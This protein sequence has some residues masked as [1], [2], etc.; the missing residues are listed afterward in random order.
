MIRH[1]DQAN[2]LKIVTAPFCESSVARAILALLLASCTEPSPETAS[3]PVLLEA[4]NTVSSVRAGLTEEAHAAIDQER[5]QWQSW[6]PA[7]FAT[8]RRLDRL[9]LLFLMSPWAGSD[10]FAQ[11][12]IP[13][14]ALVQERYVPIRVDPLRRPDIARRYGSAGW[15]ALAVALPD[16]RLVAAATDIPA[17][18]I[19][20]FLLSLANHYRDRRQDVESRAGASRPASVAAGIGAPVTTAALYANL[21]SE[22]DAVHGGFGNSAKFPETSVIRFLLAYYDHHR[23]ATALS[24]ASRALD[25]LIKA[26][27]WEEGHGGVLSYS[28]TPDWLTPIREKD[29]ADQAGLLQALLDA[30]KLVNEPYSDSVAG[31]LVYIRGELFDFGTGAFYSRQVQR[32]QAGRRS[33][34]WTDPT[35]YT[36]SNALLIMACLRAGGGE[37]AHGSTATDMA[38]AAAAYLVQHCVRA[39]GAVFH[40][41]TENGPQTPGLLDDQMLTARA[42]WQAYQ[43]SDREEF[44][45][46]SRRIVE[47]TDTNLYDDQ[48]RAF[49][50][51]VSDIAIPTW[52]S[53]AR[54]SDTTVP[55]G[56]VT[57]ATLYLS[58]GQ[59]DKLASLLGDRAFDPRAPRRA[60]ASFG[61]TLLRWQETM[62][63]APQ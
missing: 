12:D 45:S 26:P 3:T 48:E 46:A 16:G 28:F 4:Q 62:D 58:L 41:V 60:Y 61:S 36:D 49:I 33:D 56:N 17:T 63:G 21:L 8:A 10:P 18:N 37:G 27:M 54:F 24:M 59:H 40:C 44:A 9:I 29:G 38:L 39:D 2:M 5:V 52:Q 55:A 15:P 20:P 13:L 31:L 19:H 50:D 53:T 57:A 22:H 32:H 42:L 51:G 43:A 34:W 11:A 7:T 23:E 30:R 14:R 1:K 25:I 47:W 6:Q 35:V